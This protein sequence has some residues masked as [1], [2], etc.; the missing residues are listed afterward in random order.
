MASTIG[1]EPFL[2]LQGDV[3]LPT[4]TVEEITRPHIDGVS[5]RLTGTRGQRFTVTAVR[6]VMGASELLAKIADLKD[7]VGT[8]LTL[9]DDR[10][11]AYAGILIVSHSYVAQRIETSVG[12]LVA[13]SKY[14]LTSTFECIHTG[15]S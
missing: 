13:N 4:Q 10:G 3:Q 1:S 2:T 12:G 5:F 11:T 7:L 15:V 14:L 6:D 9:T 8:I